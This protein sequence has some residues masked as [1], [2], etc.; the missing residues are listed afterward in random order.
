MSTTPR[1]AV[2]E[3][4][5]VDTLPNNASCQ[6]VYYTLALMLSVKQESCEC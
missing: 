6:L 3:F 2:G 4:L 5:C 1:W